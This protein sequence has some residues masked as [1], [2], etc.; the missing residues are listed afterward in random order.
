MEK[1]WGSRF[2]EKT[3]KVVEKFTSSIAIDHKLA[4]CDL[5]GSLVHMLALKKA[6]LLSSQEYKKLNQGILAILKEVRSGFFRPNLSSEDIH[7][8]IQ[9]KLTKKIGKLALKL[10]TLRSRNDQ[11]AFDTKLFCNFSIQELLD[12][13]ADFK[14]GL[15][16][17]GAHYEDLIIPGYTHLQF[18][19]PIRFLDYV[20]TYLDM[21]K[22][23]AHRLENIA[24]E[25]KFSFGA[26]ALAGV[27]IENKAYEEAI[28]IIIKQEG[29]NVQ[30]GIL[31]NSLDAVS[32]RDFVI[33]FLGNLAILGMHLSRMAEDFIIWSSAEF[34]F[35]EIADEFCTGSSLMPQKKNPDVLELIR[36]YTGR[37]YGNLT[38]VLVMMKG[39]P[40]AYNRDMQLD[41][42]PLFSSVAI[43]KDELMVLTGL[44]GHIKINKANIKARLKDEFLY[45]TELVDLLVHK[46]TAFGAAHSIIGKLVKYSIDEKVK[47]KDMPDKLLKTFSPHLNLKEVKKRLDPF[48]AVRLK[49][50]VKK[51]TIG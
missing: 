44:I 6:G 51:R 25:L 22:R 31:N 46:G 11:V 23:D 15:L 33:E 3:A 17:L 5:I 13:I 50:S 49:K 41:K 24:K 20:F 14:K 4:E 27:S 43:V 47:I 10:H 42:E 48:F 26:G 18:A 30:C 38:S 34:G 35:I 21:L 29:L 16:K 7:T 19:Q 2:K 8:D 1:L 12:L 9:N 45:A 40:L 32:N 39:L 36:G 37:L 28:K